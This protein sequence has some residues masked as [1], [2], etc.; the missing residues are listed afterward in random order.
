[1]VLLTLREM[2]KGGMNDQLGGGFH[3]YSVDDRW[4]VPH[5]EKMLYDQAQLAISY[6]EAFQ[7]T[8][9]R[10]YADTARG[11][12]DYVLRDMTD[13]DGGFY[14]AE[15]AD[16]VIDPEHPDLK[17][18]GAFYIWS[19]EE[20]RA[21]LSQ[22]AADW[23]CYRYGVAR[24]RQRRQRSARRVHRQ[25]HSLPGAHRRGDGAAFR[26]AGRAKCRP[27]STRRASVLLAARA[28]R[29]R[30]HLDDKILTAW[31]GLM[32]SAF[33]KGGAVLDEPRYAEAARRA[34]EF[35]IA[36][37]VRRRDAASCCAAI[38]R[39]TPR[40][41]A[42][43]TTTPCSPALL[44]LYEAQFDRR[45]LELAMRLTEKQRELFEDTASAGS[46]ARRRTITGW[47]CASR[48]IT[49]APSPRA[50]RSP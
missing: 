25:E 15:D 14:S 18:E 42:S 28:K 50:T 41:P 47:S 19:I 49:M 23:F 35:I 22:P 30:P 3:R 17:G 44:D 1:M 5:F 29:V 48:K 43:S 34:A 39:A 13:P 31:N 37:P 6:L 33:A 16:S 12:F 4:F 8:G 45:H 26:P 7:I 27:R 40:S 9:D 24:R 20:I 11:I 2:A 38:A 21:L 10:Q 46:S 32:I 36:Q